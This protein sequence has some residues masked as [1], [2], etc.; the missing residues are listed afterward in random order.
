MDGG[1]SMS[2]MIAMVIA[3]TQL[4]ATD[5]DKSARK[6]MRDVLHAY[7]LGAYSDAED[8]LNVILGIVVAECDEKIVGCGECDCPKMSREA[9]RLALLPVAA[10][11]C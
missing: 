2:I 3:T 5:M 1:D 6:Q 8:A 10:P 11:H 4:G 7:R 9:I